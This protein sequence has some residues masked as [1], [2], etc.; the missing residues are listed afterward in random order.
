[1]KKFALLIIIFLSCQITFAQHLVPSGTEKK[2]YDWKNM[3]AEQ[4]KTIINNMSPEERMKL[5]REFREKMILEELNLPAEK[6]D[7]F[8]NLYNEYQN[9]QKEIKNKF[10]PNQ[11]YEKMSDEEAKKQLQQSFSIGQQLLDHRKTYSEKFM[12]IISPQ[13]VLKMYDTEGVIRNKMI[14]MKG[15]N[16]KSGRK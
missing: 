8:R 16:K 6:Q 10:S 11:D 15:E 14:D 5:L 13:K 1:M 9:G 12:K 4:R 7:D 3:S 2:T